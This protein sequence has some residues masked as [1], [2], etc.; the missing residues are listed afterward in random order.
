MLTKREQIDDLVN[1]LRKHGLRLTPQ[2]MAVLQTLINSR[3]H[4]NTEEIYQEIHLQYPMIGLATIY[5][6]I[7]LLKEMGEINELY[8]RSQ[9]AR[10]EI[11]DNPPHPHFICTQCGRI[12]DLEHKLL[13]N[14]PEKI[15]KEKGYK[16]VKTQ[17]EFYGLCQDCQSGK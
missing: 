14:L 4:L 11:Q 9:S 13:E 8:F 7:S 17:L 2:R 12:F 1:R 6:T 16:I 10:Y 3:E 15:T 5:K